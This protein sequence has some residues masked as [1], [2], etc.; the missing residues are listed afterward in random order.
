MPKFK[1]VY[2]IKKTI[3]VEAQDRAEADAKGMCE[4]ARVAGDWTVEIEEIEEG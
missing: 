2:T 3:E 4:L 1:C